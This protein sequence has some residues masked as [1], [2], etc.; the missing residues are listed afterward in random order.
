MFVTAR[1]RACP[2]VDVEAHASNLCTSKI[3]QRERFENYIDTQN[4]TYS[5]IEHVAKIGQQHVT[6]TWVGNV[7]KILDTVNHQE[8]VKLLIYVYHEIFP[9][10]RL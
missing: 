5:R 4:F 2:T 8:F 9:D 6:T 1:Q 10:F 3:I 7:Y